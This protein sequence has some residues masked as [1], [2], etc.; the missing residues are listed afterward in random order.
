MVG[1]AVRFEIGQELAG[2]VLTETAVGELPFLQTAVAHGAILCPDKGIITITS[3]AFEPAC[4]CF[5][6][7]C[8]APTC[9]ELLRE[10]RIMGR[11]KYGASIAIHATWADHI[12]FLLTSHYV[13]IGRKQFFLSCVGHTGTR[14]RNLIQPFLAYPKK[15][16]KFYS[17]PLFI[18]LPEFSSSLILLGS[19]RFFLILT[20]TKWLQFGNYFRCK[21]R[22]S[23]S[24]PSV[25]LF[26][27]G[28]YPVFDVMNKFR[29]RHRVYVSC[30][31]SCF[32]SLF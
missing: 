29:H 19:I 4:F 5:G 7:A 30:S 6:V 2:E 16:N 31:K 9:C 26:S 3:L 8:A 15:H 13:R 22:S 20:V 12:L 32:L 11:F 1:S 14:I 23:F 27:S 17:F 24:S 28:I 18:G 21:L 25:E 10:P